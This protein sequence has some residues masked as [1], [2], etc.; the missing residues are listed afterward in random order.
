[1]HKKLFNFS[2]LV[3]SMLLALADVFF[4]NVETPLSGLVH[5]SAH[6]GALSAQCSHCKKMGEGDI[7]STSTHPHLLSNC[8]IPTFQHNRAS[9][10]LKVTSVTH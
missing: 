4:Y 7:L 8:Y 2:A 6:I 3:C 10:L 9:L 1:M 5:T